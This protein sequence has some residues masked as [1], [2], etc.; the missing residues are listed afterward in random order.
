[1]FSLIIVATLI[2]PNLNAYNYRD[3]NVL[4]AADSA[5]EVFIPRLL[6][7]LAN[8][9]GGFEV[10]IDQSARNAAGNGAQL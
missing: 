5:K 7:F 1:M 8:P 2:S 6:V 4:I 9:N 3:R 10:I